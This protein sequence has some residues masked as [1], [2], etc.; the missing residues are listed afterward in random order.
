MMGVSEL[1]ME[2]LVF[3]NVA[4]TTEQDLEDPGAGPTADELKKGEEEE[5]EGEDLSRFDD[6]PDVYGA[7]PSIGVPVLAPGDED[8]VM[9]DA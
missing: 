6:D 8:M 2:E 4:D 3:D 5:E 7:L 9:E 1:G